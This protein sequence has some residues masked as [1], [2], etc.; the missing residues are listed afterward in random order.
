VGAIT[1]PG[2]YQLDNRKLVEALA[3]CLERAGGR[4]FEQTPVESI[5]VES[6][7]VRGVVAGGD[8]LPAGIVVLAAGA[9]SGQIG[10]VPELLLPPVRPVRGQIVHLA[11][12]PEAPLTRHVIRGRRAY[13]VPRP[14][15]KL[16]VGA[17]SE[18]RGFDESLTA[19]GVYDL[20]RGVYDLMPGAYE[21]RLA[22]MC[23]GL[24]PGSRDNIPILGSSPIEGLHYATGHY[25]SG[26]L[27]TP[28]TAWAISESIESG[29]V[30][31]AIKPFS[32]RRFLE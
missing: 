12:D 7:R 30:P 1:A 20:L 5:V 4:V 11:M 22:E 3:I 29:S 6:D 25:R 32:I 27:L 17:T 14:D 18:E 23:V 16:L 28:I 31:D 19:G 10:G 26:I 8:T 21:V 13:C 9:W 24:R 15:G 2:D